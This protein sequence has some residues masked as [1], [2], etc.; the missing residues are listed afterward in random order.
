MPQISR[1]QFFRLRLGDLSREAGRAVGG[2][3]PDGGEA[4]SFVRP[5]GALPDEEAFLATCERCGACANAC[6][7]DVV[8]HFGPAFGSLETTP[9]IDPAA[10]PCH[11]CEDMPC[12]EAC[13]SGALI[14]DESGTVPPVGKISL[15][16][17]KCLNTQGILCDTCSFRCPGH[18][19]AIR[20]EKRMPVL[21][22]D[23]C[24]GCGLC[25]YH[26]EADPNAFE[27]VFIDPGGEQG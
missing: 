27:F 2:S 6:P 4:V 24:T 8:R 16:L 20:M 5:P 14:R 1:R 23:R 25:L 11:W 18:I 21:D 12:I 13:P 17:D 7:Y 26:C 9:F 3:D 10:V 15:D 22:P 19:K